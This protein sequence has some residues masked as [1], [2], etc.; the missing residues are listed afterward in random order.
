MFQTVIVMAP[1]DTS[2]HIANHLLSFNPALE[3]LRI[4]L[5]DDLLALSAEV[6]AR[7]RLI[8]FTSPIVVPLHVLNAL[9]FGAYN[10]HP[11]PPSYPGLSP[12]QFAIYRGARIYGATVH[13]MAEK[14]D[15]GPIVG[16]EFCI[17]PDGASVFDIELQ[18]F[19]LLVKIFKELAPHLAT[20]PAPLPPLP[21][22]WSSTKSS[23]R[24]LTAIC[25][26][27]PDIEREE[28]DLRVK[29]FANNHFGV[30]PT[31]T[32]HG[33]T[34]RLVYDTPPPGTIVTE[35][36][37]AISDQTAATLPA[38]SAGSETRIAMS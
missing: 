24:S 10:F 11:A 21:V 37:P 3:I 9:G 29:A 25:D 16:V 17:V 22:T 27:P 32:L 5:R 7:S 14:V 35:A 33:Y 13:E 19:M 30:Q 36:A 38:R 4:A 28:L 12:A 20:N 31:I 18:S 15:S 26:I 1:D 34:F 23:R 8:A 6:F 2:E